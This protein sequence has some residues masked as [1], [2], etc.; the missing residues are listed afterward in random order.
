M[1]TLHN[2][3]LCEFM[4]VCHKERTVYV[5]QS[6]CLRAKDRAFDYSIL[7]K[8]M[9]GLGF[10]KNPD[11][12]LVYV[13]CSDWSSKPEVGCVI[14]NTHKAKASAADIEFVDSRLTILIAR[15]CYYPN[16]PE[17]MPPEPKR[18]AQSKKKAMK[19]QGDEGAR[20]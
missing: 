10:D 12:K 15:V 20:R 6:S 18:R 5:F 17:I 16:R 3:L 9:D 14:T 11:Y 7:K 2:A 8:V 4:F 19:E 13:Y 1:S